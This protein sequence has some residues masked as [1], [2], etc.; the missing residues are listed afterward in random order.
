M[1]LVSSTDNLITD[2]LY[3][4]NT[5]YQV[6]RTRSHGT[7]LEFAH[8]ILQDKHIMLEL[9][10]SAPLFSCLPQNSEQGVCLVTDKMQ[11][12]A[13][14]LATWCSLVFLPWNIRLTNPLSPP[15]CKNAIFLL[16]ACYEPSE[17][18]LKFYQRIFVSSDWSSCSDDG[19]LYI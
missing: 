10:P 16:F 12:S 15:S 3:L 2:T 4:S 14:L 9:H 18:I 8:L 17:T 19:L 1:Y 6:S 5:K 13:H 11:F 7:R